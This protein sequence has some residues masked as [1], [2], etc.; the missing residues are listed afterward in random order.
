MLCSMTGWCGRGEHI[1][2]C[3]ALPIKELEECMQQSHQKFS[4]LKILTALN[5]ILTKFVCIIV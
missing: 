4:A 3:T 1:W 5:S 2:T